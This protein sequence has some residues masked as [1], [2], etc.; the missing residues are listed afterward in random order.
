M[1]SFRIYSDAKNYVEIESV[2]LDLPRE[3]ESWYMVYDERT[4]R[5]FFFNADKIFCIVEA[6]KRATDD[7]SEV[8]EGDGNIFQNGGY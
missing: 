3:G 5:K 7:A 1:R 8:N 2:G 4:D 6:A